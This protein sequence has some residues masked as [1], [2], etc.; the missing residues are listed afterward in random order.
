MERKVRIRNILIGALCLFAVVYCVYHIALRFRKPTDLYTVRPY[1]ADDIRTFSGYLFRDETVLTTYAAG[2]RNY[3][4]YDG[5]KV[6]VG[7]IVAEVYAAGG[8]DT[9]ARL[10]ALRKQA[11]VLA[12]ADRLGNLSA[13]TVN[14]EIEALYIRI[15]QATGDAADRLQDKLLVLLAKKD[16]IAAGKDNYAAEIFDLESTRAALARSLGSPA[17]IVSAPTAG[18]FYSE[19]DGLSALFTTDAARALT[20]A[21]F[22]EILRESESYIASPAAVGVLM[23]NFRW[24]YACRTQ[25]S[26][27]ESFK[28]GTTYT[29]TFPENRCSETVPMTLCSKQADETGALLVF[30][31]MN[32]PSDFDMDR[33]QRMEVVCATY[34]GFRVPTETVRVVDGVTCVY[35]YR[36]GTAHLRQVDI[37]FEQDGYFI[38]SDTMPDSENPLKLN[39]LIVLGDPDLYDGKLIN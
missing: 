24:Y 32:V 8:E 20:P 14:K 23:T 6:A 34:T 1:S 5:E 3:T 9:T 26:V 38:V 37:L 4:H 31:T 35:V 11:K 7:G 29:C 25:A 39:D 33:C 12:E 16:Q 2:T 28:V 22:D 18:V 17:D 19:T 13:E 15:A 27:A 10:N 30:T 21:A 36:K